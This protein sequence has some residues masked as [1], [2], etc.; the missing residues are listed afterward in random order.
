MIL[1]TIFSS[2]LR[3]LSGFNIAIFRGTRYRHTPTV[4]YSESTETIYSCVFCP[5]ISLL[6]MRRERR[7]VQE[8]SRRE[9]TPLDPAVSP[10]RVATLWNILL[11]LKMEFSLLRRGEDLSEIIKIQLLSNVHKS[12]F[13]FFLEESSSREQT[14]LDPAVSPWRATGL[15]INLL[16]L[17]MDV[18]PERRG[19]GFK[20]TM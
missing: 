11:C 16:S 8:G 18:L 12:W 14:P 17:K 4:R 10:W 19:R 1:R 7:G 2:Q 5:G 9:Q 15:W 13:L 3:I 20:P 6:W